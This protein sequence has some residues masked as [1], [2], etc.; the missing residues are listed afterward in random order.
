[1]IFAG[2]SVAVGDSKKETVSLCAADCVFLF[3]LQALK[4]GCVKHPVTSLN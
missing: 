2:K 3:H 1:M 4:Q